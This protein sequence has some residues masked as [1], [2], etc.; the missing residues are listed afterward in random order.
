MDGELGFWCDNGEVI[1][2]S[3]HV[4]IGGELL[5]GEAILGEGILFFGSFAGLA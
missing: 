3:S 1:V 4:G 2:L 5:V